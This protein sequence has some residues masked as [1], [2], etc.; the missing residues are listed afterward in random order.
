MSSA[1]GK[2]VFAGGYGLSGTVVDIYDVASNTWSTNNLNGPR[3]LMS[4]VSIGNKIYFSGG[5]DV[6]HGGV[7]GLPDTVSNEVDIY[8][9]STNEW[10]VFFMA[11]PRTA[12]GSISAD[13]KIFWFGGDSRDSNDDPVSVDTTEIYDINTGSR[14]YHRPTGDLSATKNN[15]VLFFKGQYELITQVEIYT[16]NTQTWSHCE[17][18]NPTPAS[19]R[20]AVTVGNNIYI[21]RD[22]QVLKLIF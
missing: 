3:L 9:A 15:K 16:L 17:I 5:F 18:I 1:N 22:G 10:S 21:E 6:Y 8:D 14:L 12:H 11:V 20:S 7:P 13:N 4:P 2:I 19:Y